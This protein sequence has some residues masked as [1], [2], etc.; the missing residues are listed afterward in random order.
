[1]LF[2]GAFNISFPTNSI[3]VEYDPIPA[4]IEWQFFNLSVGK[5]DSRL[6][7]SMGITEFIE[8]IRICRCYIGHNNI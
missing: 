5:K 8:Y 1:M 3:I 6:L 7:E 2:K 4:Y